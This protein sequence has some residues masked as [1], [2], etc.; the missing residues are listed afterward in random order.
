MDTYVYVNCVKIDV[1]MLSG[2]IEWNTLKDF[3][4]ANV[5]SVI[6]ICIILIGL[7]GYAYFKDYLKNAKNFQLRLKNVRVLTMRIY[8]F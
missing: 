5:F 2:K 8:R 1:S 7:M 3:I 4:C 6:C